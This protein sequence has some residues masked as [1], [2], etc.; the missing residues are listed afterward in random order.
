MRPSAEETALR[1][2][3]DQRTVSPKLVAR[4]IRL[5]AM[6][7]RGM[8]TQRMTAVGAADIMEELGKI[9]TALEKH[10]VDRG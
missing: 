1:R 8:A 2:E 5:M 3:I 10:G 4:S 6:F 9:A 7:M